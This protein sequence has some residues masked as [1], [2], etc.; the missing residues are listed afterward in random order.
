MTESRPGGPEWQSV[1]D[2]SFMGRMELLG[3]RRRLSDL[4]PSTNAFLVLTEC[5]SSRRSL[6]RS[7][8]AVEQALCERAGL[9]ASW[10]AD[11]PE[12]QTSLQVRAAYA[13]LRRDLSS[14]DEPCCLSEVG[15]PGI[16]S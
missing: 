12:L 11:G 5:G 9:P 6:L 16:A 15:S 7:G 14:I 10:P 2:L 8:S 1:S 4:D 3:Q 13:R